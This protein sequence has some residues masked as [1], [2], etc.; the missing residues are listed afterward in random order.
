MAD[1]QREEETDVLRAEARELIRQARLRLDLAD[2]IDS[3]PGRHRRVDR[4]G[5]R[6]YG[7]LWVAKTTAIGLLAGLWSVRRPA[8]A[9]AMGAAGIV[10]VPVALDTPLPP[11]QS[12]LPPVID[13]GGE[14]RPPEPARD[15]EPTRYTYVE[16]PVEPDPPQPEPTIV[17]QMPD[18]EPPPTVTVTPE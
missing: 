17:V 18:P 1:K 16:V 15:E 12:A 9:G 11:A 7:H 8:V 3:K 4:Q 6:W 2:R 5:R 10:A 13:W 14:Q